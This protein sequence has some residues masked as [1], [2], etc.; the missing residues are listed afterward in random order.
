M[1]DL[2][3]EIDVS[4]YCR[5]NHDYTSGAYPIV[6]KAGVYGDTDDTKCLAIAVI[7]RRYTVPVTYEIRFGVDWLA[8]DEKTLNWLAG[9][10]GSQLA[11]IIDK[12]FRKTKMH[13]RE[14]FENFLLAMGKV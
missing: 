12:S 5:Q 9:V 6:L 7:D 4:G 13:I 1:G 8:A 3:R 11:E 14:S 10:V 2:I